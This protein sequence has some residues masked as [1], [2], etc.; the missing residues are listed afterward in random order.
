VLKTYFVSK[1]FFNF[2]CWLFIGIGF[3]VIPMFADGMGVGCVNA[4]FKGIGA[5]I[6]RPFIWA[7]AVGYLLMTAVMLLLKNLLLRMRQF[8]PG[9]KERWPVVSDAEAEEMFLGEW[10]G[11]INSIAN[12]ALA[13]YTLHRMDEYIGNGVFVAPEL[14]AD[15]L[16]QV[17]GAFYA[18]GLIIFFAFSRQTEAGHGPTTPQG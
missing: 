8:R 12:L 5:F 14:P 9:G 16:I 4:P 15:T 2:L 3:L 10:L 18:L 13:A 7:T 17:S 1:I 11:Q 6:N